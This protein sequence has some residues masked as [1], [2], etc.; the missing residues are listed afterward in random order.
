MWGFLD[1]Q[2]LMQVFTVL[3]TLLVV[4]V[5]RHVS[6]WWNGPVKTQGA[7]KKVDTPSMEA[8]EGPKGPKEGTSKDDKPGSSAGEA[9]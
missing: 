6:A 7:P 9:R 1:Q 3:L 8:S 2:I 4:A 5:M